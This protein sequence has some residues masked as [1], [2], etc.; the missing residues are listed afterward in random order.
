MR[1]WV[2]FKSALRNLFQRP[3]IESQLDDE[4]RAYV[5]MV[6]DERI[7]AGMSAAEARRTAMAEFG[8]VEQVKQTVRDNRAGT[9]AE[10]VWQDVRYALRQLRRNPGFTL[11]ALVTMGLGIGV[12]TAI[13]SAVYSLLLRPLPYH[14]ANQIMS[15]SD[16]H[17]APLIDPD[18]VAARTGIRSFEQMAGFHTYS[19]DTLTGIGDP[20]RVT[21]AAVTTNFFPV[22]GVV[23]TLGRNFYTAEDWSGGAKVPLLSDHFW[24]NKF[25]ADPKILG[26][27]IKLDGT[28]FTVIG[29]LPRHFSFPS[30]YLE[31]DIYGSAD[32]ERT[33]AV[34]LATQIWGIQTIARLGPGVTVEQA[35]ARCRP[36]F[37]RG[38]KAI[39]PN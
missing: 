11:T 22:L 14:D 9:A 13:F 30:L 16:E 19:E 10:L 7:A 35:R 29:V 38:Q 24:R 26:K 34:N 33:T 23:P 25:G 27:A 2:R 18:F 3:Q 32:L 37:S 31:P 12:T 36:L 39:Q 20:M 5:D 8:G 4:V 15:L 28:D 21:R 17:S 6:T 1:L